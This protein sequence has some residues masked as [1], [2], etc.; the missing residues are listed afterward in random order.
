MLCRLALALACGLALA[1]PSL[2]DDNPPVACTC[3]PSPVP[4]APRMR[5]ADWKLL[6]GYSTWKPENRNRIFY[7][8]VPAQTTAWKLHLY[9]TEATRKALHLNFSHYG[10][11]AVFLS[12]WEPGSTI[13]GVYVAEDGALNVQIRAAPPPEPPDCPPPLSPGATDAPCLASVPGPGPQYRLIAIRKDSLPAPVQRLYISEMADPSPVVMHDPPPPPPSSVT[14]GPTPSSQPAVRG[15]VPPQ[16]KNC[17][18]VN[19]RYP[20]GVGKLRAH[21][22]TSGT[23]ACESY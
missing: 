12:S 18:R 8:R 16:W 7:A 5:Q 9:E 11:L 2:A 20:H 15:V 19:R 10:L 22:K 23:P 13:A 3:D 17:T 14:I 1:A 6:A 21:D 4:V